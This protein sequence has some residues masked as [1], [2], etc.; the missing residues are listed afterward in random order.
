MD[1][2]LKNS[3]I[4]AL[5]KKHPDLSGFAKAVDELYSKNKSE[6]EAVK[7]EYDRLSVIVDLIPNTIS[8]INKDMTYFAVNRALA[9]ACGL[10]SFEFAGKPV[11]FHTQEHFFEDFAKDLFASSSSTI[12]REIEAKIKWV[13]HNYLVSGTKLTDGERAVVI[14]VDISELKQLQ[15]RVSF[16][17]KLATLGEMFAGII[18]DINNPLTMIEGNVYRIKRMT[19]EPEVVALLDKI[20]MSSK[21]ITKIIQGIRIYVRQDGTLPFQVEN[22][23]QILDDSIVICENKLKTGEVTL[24]LDPALRQIKINCHFTQ[25]FQ[26]FVNLIVNSIDAIGDKTEKWIEMMVLDDGE[27]S[28]M[29]RI[30]FMDSG[31]GIPNE[32]QEKIFTAF[33]TTKGRGVGSGLGL[34]LC[35]KILEAHGGGLHIDS[36]KPHTTFIVEIKK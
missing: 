9:Q 31:S 8:W 14:G 17:E 4:M 33:F 11:G 19:Q 32:I 21:K 2:D 27:K 36:G 30:Q 29:V 12:Y 16:T 28:G 15:G 3:E 23:G 10:E 25:L 6:H 20:D 7:A 26:V 5:L 35:T 22:L 24:K 13:E 34:S 18:H 1:A